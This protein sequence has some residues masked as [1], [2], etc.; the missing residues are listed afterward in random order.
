[1]F[2]FTLPAYGGHA[3]DQQDGDG[4][5]ADDQAE[6]KCGG[7]EQV[8]AQAADEQ[9]GVERADHREPE[10]RRGSRPLPV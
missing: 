5:A 8:D 1:M 2:E 7:D 6:G 10:R 9:A 3:P 4:R